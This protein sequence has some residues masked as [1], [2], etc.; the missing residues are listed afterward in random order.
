MLGRGSQLPATRVALIERHAG[1]A[2]RL[3]EVAL[4]IER[5]LG[6]VDQASRHSGAAHV[7]RTPVAKTLYERDELVEGSLESMRLG[8]A[9]IV[10]SSRARPAT[11]G[12]TSV[13]ASR[14]RTG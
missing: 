6:V 8:R 9:P 14:A 4:P 11:K 1:G 10:S 3:T 2:E 5:T 12:S 7:D 13:L